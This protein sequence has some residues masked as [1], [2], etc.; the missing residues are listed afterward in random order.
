MLLINHQE[1]QPGDSYLNSRMP[2]TLHPTAPMIDFLSM[3][4]HQPH[5]DCTHYQPQATVMIPTQESS[6]AVAQ[7]LEIARESPEGAKDPIV[8][9]ILD[10]ALARIWGRVQAQPENYIMSRDEFAVFNFFQHRFVG[11]DLAVAA[12][13]RYWDNATGP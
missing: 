5:A 10:T 11:N 4:L 3:G 8:S 1:Y 2:T 9:N 12:T 6:S 13:K 7:A